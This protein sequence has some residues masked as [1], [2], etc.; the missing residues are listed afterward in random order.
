MRWECDTRDWDFETTSDLPDMNDMIGQGRTVDRQ[1]AGRG[2]GRGRGARGDGCFAVDSEY[3][4]TRCIICG[5]EGHGFR[6]CPHN[7]KSPALTNLSPED[8]K[9]VKRANALARQVTNNSKN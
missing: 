8:Q 4:P 5:T 3:R 2:R 7:E 1:P 9:L 6:E